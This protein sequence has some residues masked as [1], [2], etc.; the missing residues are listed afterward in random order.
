M[1]KVGVPTKKAAPAPP[2]RVVE[3]AMYYSQT[4]G[5]FF[6]KPP[7]HNQCV[8]ESEAGSVVILLCHAKYSDN[9]PVKYRVPFA[10]VRNC[11]QLKQGR[12]AFYTLSAKLARQHALTEGVPL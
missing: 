10:V 1:P 4:H 3:V 6:Y 2:D 5:N 11:L 9:S 12:S 7:E 8:R